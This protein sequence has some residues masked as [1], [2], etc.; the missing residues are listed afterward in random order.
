MIGNELLNELK[1]ILAEDFGLELSIDQVVVI[2]N[3][4]TGYFE[5]LI[6]INNKER[7]DHD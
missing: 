3:D 4:L 6:A 7:S 1:Q 5:L 2:A